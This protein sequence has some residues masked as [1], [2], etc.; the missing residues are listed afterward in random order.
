LETLRGHHG[1]IT[2]LK[3]SPVDNRLVSADGNGNIRIWN[4]ALSTA[5]RIYPPQEAHGGTWSEVGNWSNDSKSIVIAGGDSAGLTTSPS[6]AI[7][8]VQINKLRM[9]NL[10][11]ALNLYPFDDPKF[12]PDD[13]SI[14]FLGIKGW[15]DFSSLASAYVFDASTG[16]IIRTLTPGDDLLIRSI[17]WSQDGLEIAT[18]LMNNQIIIWDAKTGKQIVRLVHGNDESKM[19]NHVGWSPDG[20]MMASGSDD[21]TIRVWDTRTWTPIYTLQHEKPTYIWHATWSPDGTRLLTTSGNEE[22]GA[23]DSTARIWD[24]KTG[25]E[26][27]VYRSQHQTIFIGVWSPNSRRIATASNDNTIRVWD[28]ASGEDLLT[29]SVPSTYGV[30]TWWSP[31]GEHLATMGWGTNVSIWRVWQSKEELIEYAKQCCVIRPL[32]PQERQQF[33]LQ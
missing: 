28:A 9:E 1:F 3:W 24:A 14:L 17:D 21:S 15:P 8:D 6:F 25:K 31:D 32:T 4:A 12:S 7:W 2:D 26:L 16:K 33:G 23:K 20:S 22:M 30:Y 11:D 18:G 10:N 19:V 27:L 13:R 5:W 29:L